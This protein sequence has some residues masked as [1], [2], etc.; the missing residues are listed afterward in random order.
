LLVPEKSTL[1]R[2]KTMHALS[3]AD[4]VVGDSHYLLDKAR[5]LAPL[6]HEAVIPW[7]I[8]RNM[9]RYRRPDLRFNRPLRIIV[10]RPHEKVYNN[11]FLVKALAPL[12]NLGMVEI[13]FPEA[14]SLSGHFRLHARSLIG[15][16]LRI[17][18]RLPRSKFLAFM[19]Q[20]DIY[21][22]GAL[23]DSSPASLIEAMGLGLLPVVADIPGVREWVTPRSGFLFEQFDASAL[24]KLIADL[25]DADDPKIRMRQAN[26]ERVER[27]AVFENNVAAMIDLM[28]SVAAGK[29]S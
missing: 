12:I 9:L 25:I 17:Y 18:K 1:H 19:A 5:E 16:R 21:L 24:Y 2:R 23:S 28:E 8:E 10:P 29:I 11:Q 4:C 13:V 22:S 7:G 14:G 15:D 6:R 27:E 3:H 20:H 26:A